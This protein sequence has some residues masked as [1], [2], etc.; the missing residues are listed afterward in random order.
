MAGNLEVLEVSG[1]PLT[2]SYEQVSLQF[3]FL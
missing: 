3:N 1:V 2:L